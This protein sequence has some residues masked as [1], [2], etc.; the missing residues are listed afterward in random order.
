M[1]DVARLNL[2]E[3]G[4]E[5]RLRSLMED[6]VDAY[7]GIRPGHK[8]SL[9]VWFGKSHKSEVQ[10]LLLL[11]SGP[12]LDQLVP[13]TVPLLWKTGS[14]GPPLVEIS[15]TSVGHFSDLI[16]SRAR[17]VTQFLEAPEILYFDKTLLDATILQTFSIVTEPQGLMKGWYVDAD[18]AKVK[19]VRDLL[20]S[21]SD[22][23]P[24]LGLVKVWESADFESCRG[25]IHVEH[26]QKWLP[27]SL[28][29]LRQFTYFNDLQGGKAGFFLFRGGAFYQILKFEEKTEPDYANL[30]LQR[31]SDD[32]YPEVYLR[33]VRP[34]E[35]PAA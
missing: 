35:K 19:T 32:R 16:R 18:Q 33:S 31:S 3:K 24:E 10:H 12:P 25:L 27:L 23:R 28:V 21:R 5:A 14:Q 34:S 11:Y 13:G 30:V 15:A 20:Y 17:E 6:L 26:N 1:A 9:A 29:G 22:S 7:I 4:A 8:L 2:T